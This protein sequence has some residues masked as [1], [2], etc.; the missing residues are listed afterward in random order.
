MPVVRAYATS[1]VSNPGNWADPD[2]ALGAAD[3]LYATVSPARNVVAYIQL[4][5]DQAVI[6]ALPPTAVLNSDVMLT[7]RV[8]VNSTGQSPQITAQMFDN[9]TAINAEGQLTITAGVSNETA[10]MPSVTIAHLLNNMLGIQF[11]ALRTGN[12]ARTFS[13]D[14]AW[15][16]IDWRD[17]VAPVASF[18]ANRTTLYTGQTVQFTDTSTASPTSWSWDF[19]GGASGSTAQNPLVTFNTPGTYNVVLTA[20]NGDGQGVSAPMVITVLKRE[21]EIWNGSAW[22]GGESWNGSAWV[23]PEVWDGVQWIPVKAP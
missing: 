10:A 13:L 11:G 2:N 3:D 7:T 20:T 5:F 8:G 18:T 21:A 15:V 16:D 17:A 14:A 1:L 12:Q 22:V 19:D 4:R 6:G 23:V 9:V